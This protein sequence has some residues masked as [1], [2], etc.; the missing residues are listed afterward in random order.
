MSGARQYGIKMHEKKLKRNRQM[1]KLIAVVGV[2]IVL[3]LAF[4]IAG[5]LRKKAV[6]TLQ[7]ENVAILQEEDVP[8]LKA[9]VKVDQDDG[10]TLDKKTKYTSKDLIRD[11]KKGKGYKITCKVDP[12]T[13]GNYKATIKI[14]SSLQK[15]L[16]DDWKK[17]IELT[18]KNGKVRVKNK[19]GRW[20][21]DK[22]KRY[23]GSYVKADFVNS[24]GD[25]YYFDENGKMVTGWHTIQS[26]THYFNKKGIMQTGWQ[27]KGKDRYYLAK[28]GG[29]VTGWQKIGKNTYYFE[30]DGK[31]VTGETNIGLSLCKFDKKGKL[32]SKK[33]GSV[34]PKKPMV[35]LTFDDGPGERTMEL[36]KQFEK[37]N[38]HATFFMVGQN[39]DSHKDA[40]KK[41]KEIGCEL[42]NHSYNHASLAKL[43]AKGLKDQVDKTNDKIKAIAGRGATVLRP[44]YGAI[45]GVMHEKI[46]M[47][48]ILWNID[49]L[50]W[51]TRN[52]QKTIDTVMNNVGDGDIILM[53]DIH[54]ESVDAALK[55]IP[56]L[57]KEGYQLVTVSEMA[58]A[59]GQKLENGVKYC[60]FTARTLSKAKEETETNE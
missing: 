57:E 25:I 20:E 34:D 60:D 56:K 12:K 45:G 52:A 11:L 33:A 10:V 28:S 35:A 14:S 31:M 4:V 46:K 8:T 54:T 32:V 9:S 2:C 44:P 5:A 47:P 21:K 3:I 1:W 22:F 6:L 37:Y 13:E 24:R 39:V 59:K 42:G 29:A 38:A 36:L 15:K 48:M 53:H 19:I 26:T 41:M 18:V 58:E 51:K 50:D 27:K 17:K 49:T 43:D 30:S 23:D 16:D 55:L 7:F 40:I